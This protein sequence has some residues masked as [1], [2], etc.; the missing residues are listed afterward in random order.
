VFVAIA[1]HYATPE[2]T[3]DMLAYMHRVLERTAG[4]PGLIEFKACRET[5]RTALAG[6][7]RWNSQADFQAALPTIAS[8]AP[9]RNPDWCDQPDEVITLEVP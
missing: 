9:E 1:I 2:H 4:A 5:S 8:L 7:S 3:D 6:Y